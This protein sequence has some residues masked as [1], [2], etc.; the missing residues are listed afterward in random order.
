[1]VVLVNGTN[2]Q[3]YTLNKTNSQ[4]WKL[5]S[6]S[7]NSDLY[8][9]MGTTSTTASQMA[10]YFIAK[11]GK[12]PYSG[13]SVAPTIKDFCQIYIDECKA[14]GVKAEVALHRQ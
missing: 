2:V 3:T 12:Y 10:N 1:M 6:D 5:I 9:I 8:S 11:G 7:K 13:N 14:E 4:K